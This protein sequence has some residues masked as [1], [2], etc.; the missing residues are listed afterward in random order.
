MCA[1]R[2]QVTQT[3]AEA[4][5][6]EVAEGIED[7]IGCY[8]SSSAGKE[9]ETEVSYSVLSEMH[10]SFDS[11]TQASENFVGCLIAAS[12]DPGADSIETGGASAK[13][14]SLFDYCP[15]RDQTTAAA[16]DS[17]VESDSSYSTAA[18]VAEA[19]SVTADSSVADGLEETVAGLVWSS[20]KTT[21]G[22]ELGCFVR[23][24]SASTDSYHST[25]AV[26]ASLTP[27]GSKS[28]AA[29]FAVD[30][31]A[32]QAGSASVHY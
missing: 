10:P 5:V 16:L 19:D 23:S 12:G 15:A 32:E 14:A 27:K 7:L 22:T 2:V 31:V 3:I 30:R 29:S 8:F 11:L 17:V 21:S 4:F 1:P 9:H 26:A 6:A 28:K 24:Y 13:A 18:A 25:A 20:E